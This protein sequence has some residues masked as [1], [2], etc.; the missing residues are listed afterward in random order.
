M[1]FPSFI[2]SP[3][4]RTESGAVPIVTSVAAT[5]VAVTSVAVTPVASSN[6][7]A[8][9]AILPAVLGLG[10]LSLGV[11]GLRAQNSAPPVIAV[12]RHA[13][14]NSGSIEGSAQQLLGEDIKLNGGANF[15]GDLLVPGNPRV[16]IN[17]KPDWR[18][19][20]N[21]G[22][23]NS[24]SNYQ[25]SINS[26]VN[27]GYLVTQSDPIALDNVATPPNPT[28]NRSITIN[29]AGDVAAI[30]NWNTVRDLT[31]N[32]GAP[33]V[34]APAGTYGSFNIN[35]GAL[36]LGT[37]NDSS[38]D[39]YNFQNLTFTGSSRLKIVGPVVVTVR[40]GINVNSVLGSSQNQAWLRLNISNGG[41]NVSN[42]GLVY[43]AVRAPNGSVNVNG[44]IWGSVQADH[45]TVNNGGVIKL[46]A[47]VQPTPV[48]TPLPTATPIPTATPAP[49]PTATPAPTAVPVP[50]PT[51]APLATVT[52]ILE[53]VENLGN[54]Q[55]RARFGTNVSGSTAQ[56]IPVGTATGNENKFSPAPIDRDQP[57]SFLPGRTVN[58]FQVNFGGATTLTWT[59]RGQSVTAS[60][61]SNGCPVPTPTA[62]PVPVPT[63]TPVP[64]P[65][66]T[67]VPVPTATPVPVPTATP[68]PVPTATPMPL[69]TATP[70]PLP[71]ATPVPA[72]TATPI[73]LPTATPIPNRAPVAIGDAYSVDEDTT[74]TVATPGVLRNDSDADGDV[75]RAQLVAGPAHGTLD[76]FVGGGFRYVPAADFNGADS[77]TYRA[78][79]GALSS[80][81]ATVSIAVNPVNDAP[82]AYGQSLSVDEDGSVYFAL[83]G[84]DVDGDALSFDV[85]VSPRSGA[86][87]G[88]GPSR[89]YRPNAGFFGE[90]TLQFIASD[91]KSV[92][93]RATIIFTVRHVNHAPVARPDAYATDEDTPLIVGAPG[94]LANDSDS[95]AGDALSAVLVS[96]P[97]HGTLQL[98][99]DGSFGYAPN[100]D[101]N[102]SDSFRYQPRDNGN[103]ALSGAPVT[104]TISVRPVNDAPVA[105]PDFYA[106]DEDTALDVA[107]AGVLSND[108]DADGDALTAQLVAGPTH[109]LFGLNADGSFY[110][111]PNSN[112][113]GSDS[114][115][116]RASDGAALSAPI[117]VTI[118][119]NAV[120]DA[121]VA[122]SDVIVADQG[123]ATDITLRASDVDDAPA[124]LTFAIV[125]AP[126]K[127]VLVKLSNDTYR[128]STNAGAV[129]SDSFRFN[130][131]DASGAVSNLATQ[132]IEIRR[133]ANAPIAR[134]DAY[135][136]TNKQPISGNVLSNDSSPANSTLTAVLETDASK[137]KL[138]LNADGSFTYLPAFS[139]VT[140]DIYVG[141]DSFTY[142][143]QDA[144]GATSLS[145][146][147]TIN[148]TQTNRVP[149]AVADAY[150]TH[151]DTPLTVATPGVLAN[152]SDADGD[153]LTAIA[154]GQPAHGSLNLSAN[155]GFVYTPAANYNGADS[156]TYR[157]SDGASQSATVTVNIT[158]N[159][160]NDAPVAADVD[161]GTV[162]AG[163]STAGK[164]VATD[165]DD[166][167]TALTYAVV[168][169]PAH[170]TV[171]VNSP[172]GTLAGAGPDAFRYVTTP[173]DSYAGADSFTYRATDASGAASNLARVT[174]NILAPPTAPTARNDEF[175]TS[176]AAGGP[177]SGNV[178]S[179]DSG[180]GTLTATLVGNAAQG[181][182][183]LNADGNFT[184]RRTGNFLG[185]DSF[186][187]QAVNASGVASAVAT[188]TIRVTHVNRPPSP[189]YDYYSV[190]ASG[191]LNVPAPGVLG[192]DYD[193]D[194]AQYGD[195][196]G[197][198]LTAS[199]LTTERARYGTVTVRPDGSFDYVL[200][201]ALP[202]QRLE[203]AFYYNISDGQGGTSIGRVVLVIDPTNNAPTAQS[204]SLVLGSGQYYLPVTLSGS[205]PDGE[206]I[207]YELLTLP[208]QGTLRSVSGAPLNIGRIYDT[209]G[210][211]YQ[212]NNP[213]PADQPRDS[214]TFRVRDSR[215]LT[216][217]TATVSIRISAIN[218]APV[219]V[220]DE[221]TTTGGAITIPV[222]ANDTDA[223]GD[224]LRVVAVSGGRNGSSLTITPDKQSVIYNPGPSFDP[225]SS[226]NF[227][228]SITDGF[229]QPI[230]T[231]RVTV[232]QVWPGSV[233]ASIVS[234]SGNDVVLGDGIVNRDASGQ[235]AS[236]NTASSGNYPGS[237]VYSLTLRN[238][239]QGYDKL[240]LR[241]PAREPGTS[242]TSAHWS[243]RY[244]RYNISGP[245]VEITESV[246]SAAGWTSDDLYTNQP[247]R[248]RV[249]VR[250]DETVPV[251]RQLTTLFDIRSARDNSAR[252]VV[253][254][255]STKGAATPN[256]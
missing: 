50:T 135:T 180:D 29:N 125:Q 52:P 80:N 192:N 158:V 179:N 177:L 25:V 60:A 229:S 19:Q 128:Y 242:P 71:T 168:D 113:N 106:T 66:A 123:R 246:T 204:Q 176:D 88:S 213:G 225:G 68:M 209:N 104:V 249:Q 73:P 219:A 136:F 166:A 5:P 152:D 211:F 172:F 118:T 134:D 184:Y 64:V 236:G 57:T 54:G 148:I 121:P 90:D 217:Q 171:T 96:A 189:G 175:S 132:I 114:F 224:A 59:L 49:L 27:L 167:P 216:S 117:T 141:T 98:Q 195:R 8:A 110:Y 65:T 51:G 160:V 196:F 75:L 1:R 157:A 210:I 161:A 79:D 164:F 138:T 231:G 169:A 83:T 86:L 58:S 215:G 76:L 100:P 61:N 20:R 205:D 109:G 232:R 6:K 206:P 124:A 63:A 227:T 56:I 170:G 18:G 42:N 33:D 149:V 234:W 221:A 207:S 139:L 4:A 241:G 32:G 150:A 191:T 188:V 45:L 10:F 253:G 181:T 15:G 93:N 194:I 38:P 89:I 212:R 243:I 70:I 40:N 36:I 250:A 23:S 37:P 21:G 81:V 228:Y 233:D 103:P 53:C 99:S 256:G 159:A 238:K 137:G 174:I 120:N 226:D 222:L 165:V 252:D 133:P 208:T 244:F 9:R 2:R 48:P 203:D 87:V 147:V 69:P 199:L 144:T 145:A 193:A 94:V 107:A 28:G 92:S 111:R 186:T 14:N 237:A 245:E 197:D 185:D 200:N 47:I 251:G 22:G 31:L 178:L 183:L 155:G 30:G 240:S 84:S 55:Y 143:A 190:G 130:A 44:T 255:V 43:G 131:T 34:A 154:V 202:A 254:A 41:L 153:A 182:V 77:F 214:F 95:D 218:S 12:S 119:V 108:S 151:E 140:N 235:T 127:G 39:V 126:N 82:V 91:G 7:R 198:K 142:I 11:L 239:S 116:Y 35:G 187:Y 24:P 46:G 146:T 247:L 112:F 13:L 129:G 74:L 220:A 17:G 3:R 26:S 115:T 248:V 72:P 102:G 173:G 62:T 67:P 78:N 223:D 122:Y 97:A 230:A 85:V 105:A 162:A 16:K 163:G 156:F 101:Y 201:A